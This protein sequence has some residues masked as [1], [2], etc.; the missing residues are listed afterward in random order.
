MRRLSPDEQ[1]DVVKKLPAIVEAIED[2]LVV[3]VELGRP[4]TELWPLLGTSRCLRLVRAMLVLHDADMR[5]VVGVLARAHYE[6]WTASMYVCHG[7]QKAVDE[8]AADFMHYFS[9]LTSFLKI[10]F[11]E[12]IP[13]VL[14]RAEPKRLPM[15]HLV[16]NLER[17]LPDGHPLKRYPAPAYKHLFAGESLFSSHGRIG[18][19]LQ[20]QEEL[21]DAIGVKLR[22]RKGPEQLDRL[23]EA[24]SLT[25]WLAIDSIRRDI[26]HLA[27]LANEIGLPV[28]PER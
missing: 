6:T 21:A 7:G 14:N 19:F 24:V 10:E 3:S 26:D 23:W 2:R 27:R 15:F 17:C 9:D 16:E 5:D 25:A 1:R 11:P 28:Y 22:G 20:H 13:E 18:S 12:S 8:L 4:H